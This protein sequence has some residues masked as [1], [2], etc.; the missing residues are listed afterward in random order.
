M[1]VRERRCWLVGLGEDREVVVADI[2]EGLA[3]STRAT[4]RIRLDAAAEE[5]DD[6]TAPGTPVV[7]RIDDDDAPV[8]A[9]HLVVRSIEDDGHLAD[10][11]GRSYSLVLEDRFAVLDLRNDVRMFQELTAQEIIAKVFEEAAIEP[12]TV[13]FQIARSLPKRTYCIQHRETDRNFVDRLLQH[14]G[15]FT[16]PADT[17]DEAR[18]IF[19]DNSAAFEPIDGDSDLLFR[20]DADGRGVRHLEVEHSVVPDEI[21]L[22]DWNYET[23]GVDLTASTKLFDPPRS[24]L[25]EFPGGYGTPADGAA[26][27]KI[28]GEELA[29]GRIVARGRA[30]DLCIRPGRWFQLSGISREALAIKWLVREVVHHFSLLGE[31]TYDNEIVLSPLDQPYRPARVAPAPIA[32]GSQSIKVTGPA[33][34]EIHTDDLGRMKGKFFWDRVGKDDDKASCWM[35]VVQLPTGGSQA[36]ARVGWEMLVHHVYGDPDRPVAIARVDN[37]VHPAPYAY[38]KAASAMSFKT[39]SSPASGKFNELTMEDAG[40][41]MKMGITASKDWTEQ[42]NNNKTEQIGVDEKLDVGTDL[43]TTIGANQTINVGAAHTMTVGADSGVA[44]TGDRTKTV[45]AAETVT[46]SGNVS[47]KV[48]GSDTE[49]VGASHISIAALGVNRVSKGSQSLTVG[50][51]MISVSALGCAVAVAGAKSETVGGA[52]LVLSGGTITESVIGAAA[53]TVGGACVHAAAGNRLGTAK[54][55]SNLLVGGVAMINAGGKLQMKAPTIKVTVAGIAN[56]LGG[57][58]IINMT[59]GS[60]SFVGIVGVKGSSAVKVTG[61]PNL[62]G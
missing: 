34:E 2:E 36:L 15:V 20:A 1:S 41:G 35:R 44:V 30:N 32:P 42:V 48:A 5:I 55:S 10:E 17:P 8:R 51:A 26:I 7:L 12:T 31:S 53:V 60:V 58:G 50:G 23:P 25:Y 39:M 59:P 11:E 4:I 33:G 43:S 24:S 28:R 9:W 40:S 61:G 62:V 54:G 18:T 3:R 45:G 16:I 14:E 13:A 29:S 38:P 49:T 46:V 27:A 6:E 47:E 19:T 22:K 37:A 57:G 56:F 52:K 21:V